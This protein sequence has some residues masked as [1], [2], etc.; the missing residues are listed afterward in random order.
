MCQRCYVWVFSLDLGFAGSFGFLGIHFAI[1]AELITYCILFFLANS[2]TCGDSLN[3]G[4]AIADRILG[5]YK[6]GV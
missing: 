5:K 3:N 4:L 1:L 2:Q 6:Y